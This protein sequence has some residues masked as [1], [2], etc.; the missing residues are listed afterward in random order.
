MPLREYSVME[1]HY[2]FR[3]TLTDNEFIPEKDAKSKEFLG[4]HLCHLK[5]GALDMMGGSTSLIY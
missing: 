4:K 2:V 1:L 3:M 5:V